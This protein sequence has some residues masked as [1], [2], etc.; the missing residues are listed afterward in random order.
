MLKLTHTFP[1]AQRAL[2]VDPGFHHILWMCDWYG[3]DSSEASGL[4][5]LS[6]TLPVFGI[7]CDTLSS[8][9]RDDTMRWMDLA[10]SRISLT[11]RTQ[12]WLI[13]LLAFGFKGAADGCSHQSRIVSKTDAAVSDFVFPHVFQIFALAFFCRGQ[14]S[15]RVYLLVDSVIM[16][17]CTPIAALN[18]FFYLMNMFLW[19][20]KPFILACLK[21]CA[22]FLPSSCFWLRK[23]S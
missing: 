2:T 19:S 21:V 20:L 13:I 16:H 22:V 4:C 17:K 10:C 11:G 15:S 3:S 18:H 5:S 7:W 8:R 23:V 12:S 9:R 1:V 14:R 6:R